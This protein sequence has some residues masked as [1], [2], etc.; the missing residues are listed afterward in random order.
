MFY[1]D[2]DIS[3]RIVGDCEI[4]SFGTFRDYYRYSPTM[5]FFYWFSF[6][7]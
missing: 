2:C 5:R 1:R 4:P 6:P 3:L 7:S